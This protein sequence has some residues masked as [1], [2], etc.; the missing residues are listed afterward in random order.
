MH[1]IFMHLHILA[2]AQCYG[3]SN[4][5]WCARKTRHVQNKIWYLSK[6]AICS[7]SIRPFFLVRGWLGSGHKTTNGYTAC[8]RMSQNITYCSAPLLC[9]RQHMIPTVTPTNSTPKVTRMTPMMMTEGK[10][11]EQLVKPL[12]F[13][14][15]AIGI[16]SDQVTSACI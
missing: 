11:Q 1:Q 10:I 4:S 8:L 13:R 16:W 5:E 7:T 2:E 12:K 9:S 6:T 15:I 14:A 3:T